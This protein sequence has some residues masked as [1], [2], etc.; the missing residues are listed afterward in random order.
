[1][2]S[3]LTYAVV[4]ALLW[5]L[6]APVINQGLLNLPKSNRIEAILFGLICSLIAG[7]FSLT[8]FY[9]FD[10]LNINAIDASIVA[11]GVFT[12]SIGTGLYYI[13]GHA[14]DFRA[15][16]A[17]QF[18]NVKPLLSI[19]FG[20]WVF[21]EPLST[22]SI[23]ALGFIVAGVSV[24]VLTTV[25]GTFSRRSLVAGLLLALVWSLGEFFVKLSLSEL[26]AGQIALHSLLSATVITIVVVGPVIICKLRMTDLS[27]HWILPFVAHGVLSFGLAYSF[28][29]QSISTIGLIKSILI[30]AF[31]PS[32]AIFTAFT[33]RK[34]KSAPEKGSPAMLLAMFL[35]L[36]GSLTQIISY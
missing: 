23:F 31:W 34:I 30:T 6:S 1:M 11:A 8:A 36:C 3:D 5:A 2:T 25:K 10:S 35:L 14:Y 27:L 22:G 16:Y 4:A 7:S 12:F 28:F 19:L 17:S 18:A 13:C 20:T 26:S 24:I 32:I 15:E 21:L 33:Y 9:G 29:F